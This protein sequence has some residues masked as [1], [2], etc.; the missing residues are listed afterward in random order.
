MLTAFLRL[1][2]SE[3][4]KIARV[5]RA[6]RSVNPELFDAL[7]KDIVLAACDR[8]NQRVWNL[9]RARQNGRTALRQFLEQ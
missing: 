3:Q 9:S 1:P 5:E 4:Q 8:H 2:K 7:Q 6:L